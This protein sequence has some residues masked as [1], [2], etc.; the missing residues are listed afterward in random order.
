MTWEAVARSVR[1][2]IRGAPGSLRNPG[3]LGPTKS[4]GKLSTVAMNQPHFQMSQLRPRVVKWRPQA[5]LFLTFQRLQGTG[6]ACGELCGVLLAAKVEAPDLAGIPPLVEVGGGLVILET[7]DDGAV[8][9]HLAGRERWVRGVPGLRAQPWEGEAEGPHLLVG[10]HLPADHPEGIG[11]GVVVDLDTAEG[12][13]ACACRQPPLVAV[14]IKHHSGPAG[15]DN[16]LA[17][18]KWGERK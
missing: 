6:H 18:R 16:R 10:L 12:L 13:G 7:P 9:D 11:C 3:Y 5:T 8:D 17:A 14:I 1:V 4:S 2:K 15:A